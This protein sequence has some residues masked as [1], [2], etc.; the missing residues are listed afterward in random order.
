MHIVD[1]FDDA[2]H[3]KGHDE[4]VQNGID[5]I[6]QHQF[7][8]ARQ[9]K[10]ETGKVGVAAGK[11]AKGGVDDVV[12]QRVGNRFERAADDDTDGHVDDVAAHGKRL[13]FFHKLLHKKSPLS[14]F[15]NE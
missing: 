12:H 8:A 7:T 3:H 2:E 1:G 5:E 15:E 6:T 10:G 9:G 14:A 4:E 11:D 13:E